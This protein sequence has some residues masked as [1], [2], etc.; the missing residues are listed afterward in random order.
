MAFIT[1]SDYKP[2]LIQKIKSGYPVKNSTDWDIYIKNFPFDI[3]PEMK[4]IPINDRHD[5]NGD[6][7]Y[8]PDTPV[9]KSFTSD[10]EF[11]CL[12]DKGTTLDKS[13]SLTEYLSHNGMNKI[14]DTYSGL[15]R[16]NVRYVKTSDA[17]LYKG[18]TQDILVFKVTFKFN[19]PITR[20]TLTL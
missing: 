14:Y 19:D 5:Q 8:T 17:K 9:F 16:T 10:V 7:E 18:A 20:I 3:Y 11:L 15:G 1:L 4:D 2:L 12:S 13:I 6:E